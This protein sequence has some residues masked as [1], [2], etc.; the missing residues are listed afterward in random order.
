VM[1]ERAGLVECYHDQT[2]RKYFRIARKT[3]LEVAVSPH[4]YG[5]RAY[6]SE[7]TTMVVPQE[8]LDLEALQ[9]ELLSLEERRQVLRKQMDEI[10]SKDMEIKR[11]AASAVRNYAG[12]Q[13]ESE[14]LLALLSGSTSSETLAERLEIPRVVVEESLKRLEQRGI[15]HQNGE[16]WS[17]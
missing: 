1:L 7:S 3:I 2:R 16:L 6:R 5:V 15:V 13:M 17:I 10:E 11:L 8:A 4:S 12:D 14:I 9:V